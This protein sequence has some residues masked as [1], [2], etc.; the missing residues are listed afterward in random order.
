MFSKLLAKLARGDALSAIEMAELEMEASQI[1]ETSMLAKTWVRQGTGV[2]IFQTK[3]TG[4]I[5]ANGL[6][7]TVAAGTTSYMSP[8]AN[9]IQAAESFFFFDKNITVRDLLLSTATAQPGTGNL[10][11]WVRKYSGGAASTTFLTVGI[12]PGFAA[13]QYLQT[14]I[15]AQFLAGDGI[16]F[17]LVNNAAGASAQINSVTVNYE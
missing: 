6:L 9:G 17:R 11:V 4:I 3:N 13:G 5:G 12:S 14:A 10:G 7:G 8:F 2:P 1:E 16:S 15:T